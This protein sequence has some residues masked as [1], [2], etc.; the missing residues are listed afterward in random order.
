[1]VGIDRACTLVMPLD[2]K[3]P[4]A[5]HADVVVIG[6]SSNPELA[7][8]IARE[9]GTTLARCVIERFPDGEI[10]VEVDARGVEGRDVFVVQGT[11]PESLFELLLIADACHRAGATSVCAIVPYFGYARQDRR[12][13]PGESLG[14]RVVAEV[15]GTARFGRIVTVD[16]HSDVVEAALD[17]PVEALSAVPLLVDALRDQIAHDAV[18]VAPDFGAVHLAREYARLLRLPLA[19]AQKVRTSASSVDIERVAGDVRGR[20]AVVVDDMISTGGTI[21]AAA[22][23]LHEAGAQRGIIVAATHGI[24]TPGAVDRLFRD[25]EVQRIF[26]T[27]TVERRSEE[28]GIRVVSMAPLFAR[29]IRRIVMRRNIGAVSAREIL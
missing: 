27:D 25:G 17:V 2:P 7:A 16:L 28:A 23:A 26:V 18:V 1:M 8:G 29:C 9:L 21:V 14:A 5:L 15:I 10:H 22:R 19:V 13:K 4:D 3:E 20:R 11:P 6:G 12:K 24:F